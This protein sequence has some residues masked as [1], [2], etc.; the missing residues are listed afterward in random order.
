MSF[1]AVP[2]IA[3]GLIFIAELGDETQLMVLTLALHIPLKSR[4]PLLCYDH[5]NFCRREAPAISTEKIYNSC[6]R[7]SFSHYRRYNT[8]YEMN[9]LPIFPPSNTVISS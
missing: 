9:A 3:F 8:Y 2:I 4:H 1:T 6:F 7:F 5:W